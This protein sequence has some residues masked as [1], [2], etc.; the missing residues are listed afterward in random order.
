MGHLQSDA[1][2][3]TSAPSRVPSNPRP[4]VPPLPQ[5]YAKHNDERKRILSGKDADVFGQVQTTGVE[6]QPKTVDDPAPVSLEKP[7]PVISSADGSPAKP[8]SEDLPF[9]QLSPTATQKRSMHSRQPASDAFDRESE[10]AMPMTT[11]QKALASFSEDVNGMFS[12]IGETHLANEL[13]L[14]PDS[15]R[16]KNR[17]GAA[18]SSTADGGRRAPVELAPRLKDDRS[19]PVASRTTS[20]PGKPSSAQSYLAPIT[21]TRTPSSPNLSPRPIT[22]PSRSSSRSSL[23]RKKENGH[24]SD[25]GPAGTANEGT[26]KARTREISGTTIT[27]PSYASSSVR[28]VSSPRPPSVHS[29]RSPANPSHEWLA[30]PGSAAQTEETLERIVTPGGDEDDEEKGRRLACEFLEDDFKSMA[31]DKVAMF[32]GGP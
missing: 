15:L 5:S 16:I 27:G 22:P 12:G 13:G 10:P 26:V 11:P 14:P 6:R 3:K 17:P 23:R 31:Y 2:C 30:S 19:I 8:T 25:F 32:L 7:L 28:L 18:R 9:K 21:L 20:L 29:V 1:Y 4:P 24:V